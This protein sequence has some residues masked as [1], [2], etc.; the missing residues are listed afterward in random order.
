MAKTMLDPDNFVIS[1]AKLKT[2]DLVG[3][4]LSLKNMVV[5]SGSRS[6]ATGP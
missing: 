5:G 1:A 3:I 4:T 6:G 2:H